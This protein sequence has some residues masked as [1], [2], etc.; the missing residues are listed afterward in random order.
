M[1]KHEI[2]TA[3]KNMRLA[4]GKTQTEIADALNRKQPIIG[5]WESG[6]AKPDIITLFKLCEVCGT[7]VDAAFGLKKKDT[8]ISKEDARLIEKYNSLDDIGKKHINDIFDWEFDRMAALSNVPHQAS[9]LIQLTERPD[10]SKIISYRKVPYYHRLGS[11]GKGDYLWDDLL[12]DEI[13]IP[14]TRETKGGDFVIGVDGKSMEPTYWNDDMVLVKS[15]DQIEIGEI[16]VF[17]L[18]GNCYIKELG[19][20]QLISHN[21]APAYDPISYD[22]DSDISCKGKVVYNLTEHSDEEI[23]YMTKREEYIRD[24]NEVYHM[25]AENGLEDNDETHKLVDKMLTALKEKHDTNE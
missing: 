4:S 11:A 22:E 8:V 23:E 17:I 20:N 3:I 14:D 13:E 6:Y 10:R 25:V 21:P 9:D 5:H 24:Y 16:G 19:T 15:M 12:E 18:H 1:T 2:A 7:T